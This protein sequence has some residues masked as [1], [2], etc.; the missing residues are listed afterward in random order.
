MPLIGVTSSQRYPMGGGLTPGGHQYWRLYIPSN[1]GGS[2]Y[3]MVGDLELRET[4]G[5]ASLTGT[6]TAAAS[7][8]TGGYE[9]A[10]GFD[11]SL[12]AFWATASAQIAPSWLSYDFGGGNSEIVGH[13]TLSSPNASYSKETP[14]NGIVQSSDDGSTWAT[15]W[16]MPPQT[17]W[18]DAE[19]RSIAQP[20][21]FPNVY[22]A[23]SERY[24]G[25]SAVSSVTFTGMHFGPERTNRLIA[26]AIALRSSS[27]TPAMNPLSAV[28]IGGVAAV[29]ATRS[30]DTSGST[31]EFVEMWTARPTGESGDVVVTLGGSAQVNSR[32]IAWNIGGAAVQTPILTD[33]KN[34]GVAGDMSIAATDN[35]IVLAAS[36]RTSA[37]TYTLG[38]LSSVYFSN[39]GSSLCAAEEI[40]PTASTKTIT[41]T[42]TVARIAA[43]WEIT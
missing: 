4:G 25:V 19:T 36:V 33:A 15:E 28:T 43:C 26:V 8:I 42:A 17:G 24:M 14:T 5:G 16:V 13:I 23:G 22:L 32:A 18:A 20:V 1:G 31:T 37:V 27:G 38:G 9:A 30:R 3:T 21:A 35:S 2:T 39:F 7:S 10:K 6:G 29:L 40:V 11:G 12:A 34:V 41:A